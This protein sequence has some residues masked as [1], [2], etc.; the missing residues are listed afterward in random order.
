[1]LLL[2]SCTNGEM[3]FLSQQQEKEEKEKEEKKPGSRSSSKSKLSLRAPDDP[4]SD[5][6]PAP[7]QEEEEVYW[8]VSLGTALSIV[9]RI[10]G[11][12]KDMYL[13]VTFKCTQ[14]FVLM[15]FHSCTSGGVY[16]P[17]VYLRAR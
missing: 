7:I 10:I 4:T 13:P 11:G 2:C 3:A 15:T 6:Q 9:I 8:P 16:V 1:M 12:Y 14:E 5:D 17:C